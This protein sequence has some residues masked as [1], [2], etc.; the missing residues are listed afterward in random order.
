MMNQ[1]NPPKLPWYFLKWFCKREYLPDV[2][3]DLLQY[4]DRRVKDLG[5]R[6]ANWMFTRDVLLLFRPGMIRSINESQKLRIMDL[7]LHSFKVSFRNFNKY[8]ASFL[9]NL[10]GL[11]TGLA[12]VL[13]IFLWVQDELSIDQFHANGDNLYQLLENVDQGGGMITR[14]TTAGPTSPGLME[15]FPEIE[16]AVS[17]TWDES[18]SLFLG[19]KSVATFGMYAH[20]GFFKLFSWEIT[21]GNPNQLLTDPSSIVL[22]EKVAKSLFGDENPIGKT[23]EYQGEESLKVTGVF[24]D[25]PKKSTIQFEFIIPFSNFWNNN[26]WSQNWYNTAF[27]TYILFKEGA[28]IDAFNEKVNDY[29]REKTEG[30]ASHRSPFV[31]SFGERY[32]NSKYENGVIAGG[33]IEY[34]QLFSAIALFIL[35]IAC[36]NFMN[37]STARASRRLKEI[38]V[39]KTVGARRRSLIIQFLSESILLMAISMVIALLIVWLL[40]PQ[41]NFITDKTLAL[42]FSTELITGIFIILFVAGL[43]AGSYPAFYL[44]KFKPVAVLKGALNTSTGEAWARKGLV[45]LQFTLSIVL[46]VSVIVVFEQIQ[47]TQNE[48][49]GYDKGNVLIMN[50]TGGLADSLKYSTFLSEVSKIPNVVAAS[51][52]NH[53]MT[54]HNGGTYGIFWPGKD[55]NDRTEFER[56]FCKQGFIEMMDIEIVEGRSF[57]EDFMTDWGK[58]IFNEAAITYMG[59]EDPIGTKV[60]MFNQ[61]VEIV[62]VAK[63]FHFNSFHEEVKPAFFYLE[64]DDTWYI[65][66][67]LT[68]GAEKETILALEDLHQ[69]MNPGFDLTYRFLDDDY[70]E[71]YEAENRVSALSSYFATI[72]VIISCLGLFGLSSFSLERRSKEIGIRKVLGSS[73]F[74]LSQRLV[75]DLTKMVFIAVLIGLPISYLIADSWLQSFAFRI[76]LEIWF[77]AAAGFI[78]LAIALLT[79]GYQAVKAAKLNPVQFLKDE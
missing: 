19:E 20:E 51:G 38:G 31:A 46:I 59:L 26:E 32:L 11:S 78:T 21:S 48:N 60:T 9:I 49:L 61:E 25:I 40:L 69:Q 50:V 17:T 70:Q 14:T 79:V 18:A 63:D 75:F 71:L 24:K 42:A 16:L 30:N 12:C 52:S 74:S 47:Y 23:I 54:G 56:M 6:K 28:D 65:M 44:S 45:T 8:R 77:F 35:L 55:P 2:E 41:F 67:K 13:L 68:A 22:S 27:S 1:T 33:R 4:Y 57:T 34:V 43:L 7:L 53:D 29:V 66:A 10:L 76:Q 72:A 58:I 64:D 3:G 62:G 5:I 39:K 37:L 36:I 73:E 15:D